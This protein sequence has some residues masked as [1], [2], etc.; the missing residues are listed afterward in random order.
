MID[1][2]QV[3]TRDA[4]TGCVNVIVDTPK[5]SRNKFKFDEQTGSVYGLKKVRTRFKVAG[6][7]KKKAKEEGAAKP[8]AGGTAAAPAAKAGAKPAEK[9]PAAKK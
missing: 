2:S 8:A 7:V 3:E 6:G 9:K 5:G 4:T 1:L